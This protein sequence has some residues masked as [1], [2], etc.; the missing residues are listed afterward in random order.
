M[1]I[2][3]EREIG[4]WIVG[5]IQ[6][7]FVPLNGGLFHHPLPLLAQVFDFGCASGRQERAVAPRR[8][9]A[10]RGCQLFPLPMAQELIV[11]LPLVQV[12]LLVLSA[13]SRAV[14]LFLAVS[15]VLEH[16]LEHLPGFFVVHVEV[17]SIPPLVVL[18]VAAVSHPTAFPTVRGEPMD[19]L[20]DACHGYARTRV[21]Q[22]RLVRLFRVA[23][24]RTC[25]T[26]A[27]QYSPFGVICLKDRIVCFFRFLLEVGFTVF[28]RMKRTVLVR[29]FIAVFAPR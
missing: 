11:H 6:D 23:G 5:W 16:H 7:V 12:L 17:E 27:L 2:R 25:S 26:A 15:R 29:K 3:T 1:V 8:D 20:Q 4:A 22:F 24:A 13:I 21:L 9:A 14:H 19:N 10:S 18:L 28:T